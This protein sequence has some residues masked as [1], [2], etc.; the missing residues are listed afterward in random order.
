MCPLFS[1]AMIESLILPRDTLVWTPWSQISGNASIHHFLASVS[2]FTHRTNLIA[3]WTQQDQLWHDHLN[4][5]VH[6][7]AIQ[8]CQLKLLVRLY[9]LV[10]GPPNP[11]PTVHGLTKS[12]L[13]PPIEALNMIIM[14]NPILVFYYWHDQT[15]I[16]MAQSIFFRYIF[17]IW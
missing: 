4:L 2:T 12:K 1:L 16:S 6:L 3:F 15:Y 14:R 17:I 9:F 5:T 7:S 13:T 8:T 10:V 11:H